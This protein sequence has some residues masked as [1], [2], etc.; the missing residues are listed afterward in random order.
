MTSLLPEA[1][2]I[3]YCRPACIQGIGWGITANEEM[4]VMEW[5][6]GNR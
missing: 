2:K 3:S 6:T 1:L 5:E 4:S